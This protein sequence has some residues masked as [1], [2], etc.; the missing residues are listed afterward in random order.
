MARS[1]GGVVAGYVCMAL[2]VFATF[3]IT[4]LAMGADGAFQ[5]GSYEVSTLWIVVSFAL[6]VGAAVVGGFV[7]AT[8]AKNMTACYVLAGI[9]LVL[10]LLMTIPVLTGGYEGM[11]EVRDGSV[12]NFEAMQYA[13]QPAWIAL[14]NPIIGA[15][16]IVFG[17]RMKKLPETV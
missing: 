14:L 12:G 5:A 4:Y 7:C 15:G 2:F 9:V 16:G 6:S 1:I 11:P 8:I 17:G 10:G 3:S 13:R